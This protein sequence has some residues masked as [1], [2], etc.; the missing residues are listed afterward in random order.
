MWTVKLKDG[1]EIVENRHHPWKKIDLTQVETLYWFFQDF[2][3]RIH[4]PNNF[5]PVQSRGALFP[6]ME[7]QNANFGFQSE[8]FDKEN[9]I[10]KKFSV[11][12]NLK[13]ETISF[14]CVEDGKEFRVLFFRKADIVSFVLGGVLPIKV[15]RFDEKREET[16]AGIKPIVSCE[17]LTEN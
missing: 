3:F 14:G 11:S 7:I 2:E 15:K 12:I 6:K 16:A 17:L 10:G 1:T 5:L 8:D 13:H 9:D 4:I